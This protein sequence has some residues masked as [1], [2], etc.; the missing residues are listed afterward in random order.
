M[1]DT[2]ELPANGHGLRET[3]FQKSPHLV[4][5]NHLACSFPACDSSHWFWVVK[6][7]HYAY[8]SPFQ[9]CNSYQA[10][11]ASLLGS[12]V[13]DFDWLCHLFFDFSVLVDIFWTRFIVVPF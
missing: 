11:E 6:V 5:I 13:S 7:N 2:G 10:N 3:P 8:S 12:G 9:S 4:R 1:A